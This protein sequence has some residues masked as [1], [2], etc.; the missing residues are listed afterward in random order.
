MRKFLVWADGDRR[1]LTP[2]TFEEF[3][4]LGLYTGDDEHCYKVWL[5]KNELHDPSDLTEDALV[6]ARLEF[7]NTTARGYLFDATGQDRWVSTLSLT[8]HGSENLTP[9]QRANALNLGI[10]YRRTT[11]R[12]FITGLEA[13]NNYTYS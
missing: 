11:R 10:D 7:D 3:V 1:E 9:D 2:L 12:E 5:F 8:G 4:S 6:K 13:Y